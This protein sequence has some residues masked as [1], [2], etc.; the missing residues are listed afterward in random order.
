MVEVGLL[1]MGVQQLEDI[2][3]IVRTNLRAPLNMLGCGPKT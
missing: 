2:F 1:I 3:G